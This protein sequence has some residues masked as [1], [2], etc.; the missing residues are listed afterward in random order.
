MIAS[1][2]DG[3]VDLKDLYMSTTLK[4]NYASDSCP[5]S[6]FTTVSATRGRR[7]AP[8]TKIDYLVVESDEKL[9]GHKWRDVVYFDEH[10]DSIDRKFYEERLIKSLKGIMSVLE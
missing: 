10:E 9:Q 3:T 8:G 6:V 2:Y 1:L 4:G 5:T 7:Y